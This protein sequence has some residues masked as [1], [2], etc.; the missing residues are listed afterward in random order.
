[1]PYKLIDIELETFYTLY[2]K[3]YEYHIHYDIG[4]LDE[5]TYTT[6]AYDCFND[7]KNLTP[8]TIEIL[9]KKF[10]LESTAESVQRFLA[11]EYWK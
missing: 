3:D 6:K 5:I 1:M 7:S 8:E 11:Q 10:N 4:L 2:S 9:S